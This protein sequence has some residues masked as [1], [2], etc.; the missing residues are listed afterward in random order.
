MASLNK[1]LVKSSTYSSTLT[2]EFIY[3]IED[4]GKT[5]YHY[6]IENF[7]DQQLVHSYSD[8]I[9]KYQYNNYIQIIEKSVDPIWYESPN[10]T[11]NNKNWY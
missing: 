1:I 7:R 11:K 10:S 8:Q 4:D 3:K 5:S 9:T 2:K 6:L